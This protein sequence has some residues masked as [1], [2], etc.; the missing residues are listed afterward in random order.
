MQRRKGTLFLLLAGLMAAGFVA[1]EGW[2]SPEPTYQGQP[3]SCWLGQLVANDL[4]ARRLEFQKA[5]AAI[6][7]IGTNGIPI[8]L[9][10]IQRYSPLSDRLSDFVLRLSYGRLRFD[11]PIDQRQRAWQAFRVLGAQAEP[12]IPALK[13][14]VFK[15]HIHK[16][17]VARLSCSALAYIGSNGVFALTPMLTNA[18]PDIRALAAQGLGNSSKDGRDAIPALIK[19]L[20]DANTMVRQ[21]AV[22]ALGSIGYHLQQEDK[23]LDFT[24]KPLVIA[25]LIERLGDAEQPVRYFAALSLGTCRDPATIPRLQK[26]TQDKDPDVCRAASQSIRM[27]ENWNSPRGK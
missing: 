20:K 7:Q 16:A 6:R 21:M 22:V 10:M 19:C 26:A 25:A 23:G 5:A 11:S 3:L 2:Q 4:P 27:I 9:R 1:R 14:L 24:E 13:N 15:Y 18:S 17:E 12:A 8:Y